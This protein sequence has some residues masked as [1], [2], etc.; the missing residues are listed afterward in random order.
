MAFLEDADHIIKALEQYYQSSIS[1]EAPAIDQQPLAELIENLQLASHVEHGDL[2]GDRLAEF[3][4]DYLSATTRLHHPG[5]LAHQV[6]VPHYSGALASLIDGFSNNT[7]AI[8]EMGPAAAGIE[9]FV[10]NWF[11]KKIG[12]TP[13]P[14]VP[15]PENEPV[16]GGV[17]THGGSLANLTALIAARSKLIPNVWLEGNPGN[18]ALLVPEESHYSV[19]R[20]AGILGIGRNSVYNLETDARGVVIPDRLAATYDR[21]KNDGKQAIA[22]VANAC[23]TGLG[24]YDPLEE[25][26]EFCQQHQLWFHIDGAH[27]FMA[28]ISDQYGHLLKGAE[29]ADSVIIDTHKLLRTPTLCAVVLVKNSRHLDSAFQQEASYLFHEKDQPGIDVIHRTVECTKAGLGLRFFM[30]LA[31]LGE[32]GLRKYIDQQFQKTMQV[33]EYIHQFTDLECPVKPQSNILCFRVKASDDVQIQIRNKLLKQGDFYISTTNFNHKRYL[34]IVIMNPQTTMDDIK[35]LLS[36]I[37][38]MAT[39][40]V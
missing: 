24:L 9:F 17:L 36:T 35:Q 6:A 5:Y 16:G 19:V 37:E 28:K 2:T 23:S 40:S 7:M 18:L 13:T 10:I 1:K 14:L 21:L 15:T 34:R 31:A 33:Y 39:E 25:I 8:Y 38:K 27:G 11:L 3:I 26:A 12:W 32:N 4:Y 20:T 22:L 30:V 29:M